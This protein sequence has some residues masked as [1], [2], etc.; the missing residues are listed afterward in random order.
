MQENQL[1]F[2]TNGWTQIRDEIR[3]SYFA[4]HSRL[5]SAIPMDDLYELLREDYSPSYEAELLSKYEDYVAFRK[6]ID[7]QLKYLDGTSCDLP[8]KTL[9]EYVEAE[10]EYATNN[11][12]HAMKNFDKSEEEFRE[13]CNGSCYPPHME[14]EIE[15]SAEEKLF[16]D[17]LEYIDRA[18]KQKLDTCSKAP[19]ILNLI[20]NEIKEMTAVTKINLY[21]KYLERF[22]DLLPNTK[23]Q[24]LASRKRDAEGEGK[25]FEETDVPYED[26]VNKIIDKFDKVSNFAFITQKIMG[27]S[28]FWKIGNI[29]EEKVPLND[30]EK[31]AI[32]WLEIG[33]HLNSEDVCRQMF[34]DIPELD[35]L[36]YKL[37]N[38]PSTPFNIYFSTLFRECIDEYTYNRHCQSAL[39]FCLQKPKLLNEFNEYSSKLWRLEKTLAMFRNNGLSPKSGWNEEN[40]ALQIQDIEKRKERPVY[41][42]T[43]NAILVGTQE[44]HRDSI[45]VRFDP[46]Q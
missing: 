31:G 21:H 25:P 37:L 26:V 10:K 39:F 17:C 27:Y 5:R 20:E 23:E 6:R 43:G 9:K 11:L 45:I 32:A 38:E 19:K 4:V 1:L 28:V 30:L 44:F 41:L 42:A 29:Q 18:C 12:C 13:M 36:R 3:E 7:E 15:W 2:I 40:I 14:S 34:F 8:L 24:I 33:A 16:D 35:E 46:N 22:P